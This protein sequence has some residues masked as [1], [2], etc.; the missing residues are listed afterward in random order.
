MHFIMTYLVVIAVCF[1]IGSGAVLFWWLRSNEPKPILRRYPRIIL[2]Q[3]GLPFLR[4]RWRK[5]DPND[6]ERLNAF[7]KRLLVR[8]VLLFVIP[9]VLVFL[10]IRLNIIYLENISAEVD[11]RSE[12]TDRRV[13]E[14]L[15][16]E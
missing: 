6:F 2:I 1:W 14:L 16:E 5:I 12:E 13:E 11:K 10:C 15:R 4:D 3:M 9:T 7:R 8:M